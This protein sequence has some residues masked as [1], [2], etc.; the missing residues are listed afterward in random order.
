MPLP[1]D[2]LF[3]VTALLSESLSEE[4]RAIRQAVARFVDA[5]GNC[6]GFRCFR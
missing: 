4:E 1:C 5:S 3:N 2:D 6:R